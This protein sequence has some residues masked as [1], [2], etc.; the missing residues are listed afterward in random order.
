[1]SRLKRKAEVEIISGP[2]ILRARPC[3]PGCLPGKWSSETHITTGD[4]LLI[5]LEYDEPAQT[6]NK[7]ESLTVA[8]KRRG[9]ELYLAVDNFLYGLYVEQKVELKD[10]S[11]MQ[12]AFRDIIQRRI[13]ELR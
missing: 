4:T 13:G 1:M 12:R 2:V 7:I 3:E 10:C 9:E 5:E 11:D 8:D 6:N